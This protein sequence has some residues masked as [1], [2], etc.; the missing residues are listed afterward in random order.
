MF[1]NTFLPSPHSLSLSM[2]VATDVKT[3]LEYLAYL[4]YPNDTKTAIKITHIKRP[5]QKRKKTLRT[6][7]IVNVFGATGSGKSSFLRSFVG[8]EFKEKHIPTIRCNSVVNSISIQG[9]D[10][11][12]VVSG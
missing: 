11:Y 3:T 6:T 10:K 2:T 12:L 7:F 4:G 1:K 9:T 5:D 8:K